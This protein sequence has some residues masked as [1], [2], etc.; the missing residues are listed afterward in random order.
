MIELDVNIVTCWVLVWNLLA[1]DD[2]CNSIADDGTFFFFFCEIVFLWKLQLEKS[3]E[4]L[5]SF[6]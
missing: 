2:D 1:P 3:Y 4:M 6:G 5:I